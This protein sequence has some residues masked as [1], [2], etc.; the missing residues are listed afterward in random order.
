M[1]SIKY[2]RRAVKGLRSLP[3]RDRKKLLVALADIAD[4]RTKGKDIV[5]LKGRE[6][7]RYR[8]GRY[9][10][11]YRLDDVGNQLIIM[12]VM[13]VGPRGGIYQ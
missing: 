12:V 6:G 4:G 2:H 5:N 3:I 9:R 11:I 13:D 8:Q 10:A 1:A 7:F